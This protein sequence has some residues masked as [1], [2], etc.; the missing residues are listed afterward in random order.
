MRAELVRI[1][2]DAIPLRRA[3]AHSSSHA[4]VGLSFCALKK[5]SVVSWGRGMGWEQE[6][7]GTA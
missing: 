2:L 7:E 4:K 3:R 1:G 5:S 6:G